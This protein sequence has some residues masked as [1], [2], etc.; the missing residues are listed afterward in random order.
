M[1]EVVLVVVEEVF[2]KDSGVMRPMS[3][4]DLVEGNLPPGVMDLSDMV[5]VY[6]NSSSTEERND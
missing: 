2:D 1:D 5:V 4:L 6:L 3:E